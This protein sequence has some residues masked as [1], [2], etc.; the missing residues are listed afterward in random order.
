M[1]LE[2]ESVNRDFSIGINH[3]IYSQAE[4]IFSRLERWFDAKSP[5]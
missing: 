5:Q 1:D 2:L 3:P 4:D